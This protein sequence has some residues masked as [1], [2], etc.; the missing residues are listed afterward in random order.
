MV[1]LYMQLEIDEIELHIEPEVVVVELTIVQQYCL[2]LDTN[3]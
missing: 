3:E 1:Q 2:E